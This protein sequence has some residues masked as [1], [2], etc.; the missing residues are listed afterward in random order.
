M[1]SMSIGRRIRAERDARGID[2]RKL[3][4]DAGM[5]Y[6]TLAG[7]ENS[8]QATTTRLHAIAEALGVNPNWLESGR[9][10]KYV[11]SDRSGQ[12]PTTSQLMR[13]DGAMLASAYHWTLIG[14][15]R[16]GGSDLNLTRVEDADVLGHIYAEIARGGGDLID[17][18]NSLALEAV[19]RRRAQTGGNSN[20]R[21]SR[22]NRSERVRKSTK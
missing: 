10:E 5:A 19:I 4:K 6:A 18:E 22:S 14:I 13:P 16:F 15:G 3:A 2:R 9:G 7:L 11:S 1:G 17:G 8:D 20:A 21:D 12:P